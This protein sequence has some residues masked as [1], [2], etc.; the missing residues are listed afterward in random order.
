MQAYYNEIDSFCCDWLSNLMDAGHITPGRIDDRDIREVQ[1]EDLTRYERVHFFAGIAGWDLALN[2][3][4][5]RGPVWTGS[6]PCQPFS[7]AGQGKGADDERHLWPAFHR[8][9]AEC[10]PSTV[11]GEQVASKLGRTWLTA[12][13]ADLE[14]LGYAVGAADLCAAGV[15]APHIRQRLWWVADAQRRPAKRHGYQVAGE[16]GSP[17]EEIR[18]Q[19]VRDDIGYGGHTNGHA[20]GC[21]GNCGYSAFCCVGSCCFDPNRC[22][23]QPGSCVGPRGVADADGGERGRLTSGEGRQHDRTATGRVEG[24]RQPE[25]GGQDGRV[26]NPLVEGLERHTGDGNDGNEPGRVAADTDR[27]AAPASAWSD[28]EWLPCSDGKSRPAQPGIFPLVDRTPGRVGQ[29]RA[30]GNA[31]VP[32]VAAVFIRSTMETKD[33]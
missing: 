11:F 3:A 29:L 28:I 4:G 30:Y 17:S 20:A 10:G 1:P 6:C 16:T 8:L 18:Q 26:V 5:W 19:R 7:N 24:Y 31:I 2:L 14:D 22:D 15:G 33:D 25:R 32:Q 9:V 13:R 27:P 23:L 12:V 21:D